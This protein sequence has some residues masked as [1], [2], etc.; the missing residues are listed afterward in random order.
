M[1]TLPWTIAHEHDGDVVVLAS[2]LHLRRFRHVPG[3]LR[4]AL[5]IRRQVRRSPGAVGVSLLAQPLRKTF[6][7]LSAWADEQAIETFVAAEPHRATMAKY[8]DRLEHAEFTTW[9][10]SA[11]T[12][13][14]ARTNARELWDEG[15]RHLAM[16]VT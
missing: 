10:V 2:R 6:W 5:A 12:L 11:I 16:A 7:T 9:T 4:E 14:R 8:H 3:F 1:P 13:P 15:K